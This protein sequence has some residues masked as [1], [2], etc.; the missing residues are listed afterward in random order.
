MVNKYPGDEKRYWHL[1]GCRR[2]LFVIV[3][4]FASVMRQSILFTFLTVCF[5]GT[6]V[7][8]VCISPRPSVLTVSRAAPGESQSLRLSLRV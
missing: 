4:L 3:I 1:R 7:S 8:Y 6:F 2:T 5:G